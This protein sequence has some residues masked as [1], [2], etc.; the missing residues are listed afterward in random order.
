[1]SAREFAA[2][3]KSS[4]FRY[5]WRMSKSASSSIQAAPAVAEHSPSAA[6]SAAPPKSAPRLKT[7]AELRRA[8]RAAS[9]RRGTYNPSLGEPNP[10]FERDPKKRVAK[11]DAI[12]AKYPGPFSNSTDYIRRCRDLDW[13]DDA[14]E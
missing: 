11:S 10:N 1:M 4:R 5:N 3:F 2:F 13:G 12:R 7:L 8:A 9:I 6:P 14:D